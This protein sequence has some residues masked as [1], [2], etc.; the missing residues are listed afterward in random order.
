MYS[1]VARCRT[2]VELQ[3]LLK[4]TYTP[5]GHI[6]W[7]FIRLI[8]ASQFVNNH[9]V[10]VQHTY[11]YIVAPLCNVNCQVVLMQSTTKMTHIYARL[12]GCLRML[13]HP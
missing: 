12:M 8:V 10:R 3:H 4:N 11:S 1:D 13:K 9:M 7:N 5:D 6:A 2:N